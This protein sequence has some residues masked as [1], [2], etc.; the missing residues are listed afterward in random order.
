MMLREM[1]MQILYLAREGVPK[2]RIARQLGISRQTVYNHL[3]REEPF[4]KPRPVRSSKLDAFKAYIQAQ[5]EQFD[6]PATVLLRELALLKWSGLSRQKTGMFKVD[7][8][9]P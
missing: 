3:N 9:F 6:L 2:D 7:H 4:P 8:R 5:L 1:S